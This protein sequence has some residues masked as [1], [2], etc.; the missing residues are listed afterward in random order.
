MIGI[1]YK[2]TSPSGKIYIGQT[3]QER[4]RR[5]TFLNIN[6][7]YGGDKID[8]ARKKYGPSSFSYEV[9]ERIKFNCSFDAT[10][11]LDE[12]ESF[13][14]E[15]YDSYTNG[16][17]M[18]LGGYTTR[19]FKFTE[20][21][22]AKMSQARIGKPGTPRTEEEKEAQS[23]R[24]KALYK[25]PKWREWRREIDSDKEH[26]KR[27][28]LSLKGEKNGMFGKKHSQESCAKMSKSRSGEKN[29]WYGK[30][31][32]NSYKA[33]IQASALIYHN[34]HPITDAIITKISKNISIPVRQLTLNREPIA[35]FDS[36][37]SAGELVGIDSSCIVKCCKGKRT[38]A[39][40]FRWEYVNISTISENIDPTIWIGTGEAVQLVGHNRNVL[41]YHMDIIKDIPYKKDG[42]KRYIHK[43][44]LLKIFINQ[45]Y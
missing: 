3:T 45:S 29:I 20:E 2:Y 35:E 41:Y 43:P 24:M 7:R 31:K 37:K 44:T 25:D 17:N 19:G 1:I 11:K 18:T 8:A 36:T 23:V 6:K 21:Q 30:K 39:G 42:R 16:Y 38:T 26:R 4:R 27:L 15:K 13:Y 10:L 34:E 14:I 33:K 5:K 40:G 32:S 12:L 22:R 9:I 28:S